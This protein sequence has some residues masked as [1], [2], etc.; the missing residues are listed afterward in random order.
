MK[1]HVF[2][3]RNL[4]HW[5]P[6]ESFF[7]ITYRLAGS[8]PA[9]KIADLKEAYLKL[10]LHPNNISQEKQEAV[11]QQY[12]LQFDHALDTNLNE[13]YWL[14]NN[15]IAQIVLDS[16]L[17]NHKKRYVLWCAC[18]MPN[19]VHLLLQT[20]NGAPTL[21]VILQATKNLPHYVATA[22]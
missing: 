5:Q 1:H 3:R 15:R 13:P 6:S 12:F 2:Y 19:H 22:Y 14:S 21:D 16:L 4:P 10:R 9:T 11:Q 7:F 18:I 8:L 20:L 17:F